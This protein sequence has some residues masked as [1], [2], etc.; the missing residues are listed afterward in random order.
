V[1]I[2]VIILILFWF[3]ITNSEVKALEP[4]GR[5]DGVVNGV[6]SG[7]AYDPDERI[8]QLMCI[9]M[10]RTQRAERHFWVEK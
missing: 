1:K 6:I 2:R 7:W 5:V 4:K 9:F 3:L 10:W 8:N